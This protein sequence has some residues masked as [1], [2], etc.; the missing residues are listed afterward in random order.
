MLIHHDTTQLQV[1]TSTTQNE[2]QHLEN[3]F[4][5]ISESYNSTN[6]QITV[7]EILI[8]TQLYLV[9]QDLYVDRFFVL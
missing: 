4:F 6:Y 1:L 7:Y 9:K 8:S 2:T 3:A 5:T